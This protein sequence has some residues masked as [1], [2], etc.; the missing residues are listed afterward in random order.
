MGLG[1]SLEGGELFIWG[2]R[3][4]DI[5]KANTWHLGGTYKAEMNVGWGTEGR[6]GRDGEWKEKETM[7]LGMW[8][9][10]GNG[11]LSEGV[12]RQSESLDDI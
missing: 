11:F 9:A 4:V 12:T 1:A 6:P 3:E 2:K 10:V 8:D 7:L 5:W